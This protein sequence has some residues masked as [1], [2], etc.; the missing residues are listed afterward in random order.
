MIELN[1]YLFYTLIEVI[2]VLVVLLVIQFILIRKY[3]PHY[4]ANADPDRFIRRYLDKVISHTRDYARSLGKKA[5]A[6][7]GWALKAQQN[8]VARLNWLVLEKDF[9]INRPPD[10]GYWRDLVRHIDRMLDNWDLVGFI[11]DRPSQEAITITLKHEVVA[12]DSNGPAVL[13][14]DFPDLPAEV[15]G[16]HIPREKHEDIIEDL[17]SKYKGRI[18]YLE[19]Q[20]HQLDSYKQMFYGLQDTYNNISGAYRKMKQQLFDLEIETDKMDQLKSIIQNHEVHEKTMSAQIHEIEDSKDRMEK[21]LRQLE[22]AY[23]ELL[24]ETHDQRFA[25]SDSEL[26]TTIDAHQTTQTELPVSQENADTLSDIMGN[27][28]IIIREIR[29][30]LYEMDID[31]D[32]KLALEEKLDTL[33]KYNRE[34]VTVIKVLDDERK[35]LTDELSGSSMI[36]H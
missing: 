33:D 26:D 25:I 36:D 6:G 24:D 3:K 11:S 4:Q 7:S 21:E 13:G 12:S 15:S 19:R 32:A 1:V 2:A 14:D 9:I 8:L 30:A 22:M 23:N 16:D 17:E 27:Q 18:D 34:F 28:G 35:R 29:T 20:V 31:I 5:Q 10:D